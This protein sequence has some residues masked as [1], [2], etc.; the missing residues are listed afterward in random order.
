MRKLDFKVLAIIGPMILLF[1]LPG[2]AQPEEKKDHALIHW[3]SIEE[4]MVQ[5]EQS[6]QK[7]ILLQIYT[8]WCGWCKEM[9]NTTYSQAHIAQYISENFYPVKFNAETKESIEYNGKTYDYVLRP[10][11]GGY[12]ELAAELLNGR[13]SFPTVVFL[14]EGHNHLQ[15]IV[16]FKSPKQFETII[17]YFGTEGYK[18]TPWA[19][20]KKSYKSILMTA[21]ED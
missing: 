17:T 1:A 20:Y 9:E 15:S 19:S 13:F 12:H 2:Y 10:G 6:D 21:R 18:N 16:G 4:A 8:D 11:L 3:M 5:Q 7:K 14:D